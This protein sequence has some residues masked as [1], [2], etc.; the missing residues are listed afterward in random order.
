MGALGAGLS[1]ATLPVIALGRDPV[2]KEKV[3]ETE[4]RTEMASLVQRG[5]VYSS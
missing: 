2:V 3:A 1:S 4:L 5:L